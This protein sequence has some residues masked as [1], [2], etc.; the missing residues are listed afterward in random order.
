MTKIKG[1]DESKFYIEVDGIRLIVEEG[2]IVG[3]YR[4]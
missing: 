3:W 4:P 1:V 2:K